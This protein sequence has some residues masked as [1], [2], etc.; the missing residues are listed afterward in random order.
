MVL[1]G[2]VNDL[3]H[4]PARQFAGV[5]RRQLLDYPQDP[6]RDLLVVSRAPEGMEKSSSLLCFPCFPFAKKEG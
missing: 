3:L 2:Q 5:R 1:P 4:G 6:L